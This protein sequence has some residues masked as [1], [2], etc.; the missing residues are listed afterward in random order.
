M[1]GYIFSEKKLNNLNS[2]KKTKNDNNTI[3]HKYHKSEIPTYSGSGNANH[4]RL[5]NLSTRKDTKD[6]K[7]SNLL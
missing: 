4:S 6:F 3:K 5:L 7:L 1:S 2:P